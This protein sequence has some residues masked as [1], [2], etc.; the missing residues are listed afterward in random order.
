VPRPLAQTLDACLEPDPAARP[1]VGEL[2][3]ALDPFG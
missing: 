2:S 3:E 1:A